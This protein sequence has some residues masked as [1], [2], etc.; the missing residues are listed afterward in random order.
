MN[1][2]KIKRFKIYPYDVSKQVS[3]LLS[4]CGIITQSVVWKI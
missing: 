2:S 4:L 3:L 1:V